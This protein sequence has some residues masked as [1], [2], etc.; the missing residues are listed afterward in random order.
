MNKENTGLLFVPIFLSRYISCDELK[1]KD[2]LRK[3][4]GKRLKS[5]KKVYFFFNG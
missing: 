4:K 5:S 1:V 2:L 3:T